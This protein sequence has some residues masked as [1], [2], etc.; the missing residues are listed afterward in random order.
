M[1]AGGLPIQVMNQF[2]QSKVQVRTGEDTYGLKI[3]TYVTPFGELG[4]VWHPMLEG[5]VYGG[6]ALILDTDAIDKKYLNGGVGGFSRHPPARE[7]S[8]ERSRRQK[9]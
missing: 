4:V 7:H 8:G 2:A 3:T 5:T 6:V 9:R 1:L